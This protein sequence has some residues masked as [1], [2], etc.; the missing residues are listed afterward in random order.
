ML[1]AVLFGAVLPRLVDVREVGDLLATK[2]DAGEFGGLVALTLAS[3]AASAGILIAGLPGLR[4]R[5]AAAVN[6]VTTA[7]SY[8]LPAGGAAGAALN[9]TMLRKVGFGFQEIA[10]QALATGV[11]NLVARLVLPLAALGAAAFTSAVPDGVRG[12]G[13]LGLALAVGVLG[14][15][16][17]LFWGTFPAEKIARLLSRAGRLLPGKPRIGADKLELFRGEVRD[18]VH[19]RWA[20][21]SVTTLAYHLAT[22]GVLYVSLLAVGVTEAG[23]IETFA[24]YA[25]ARQVTA[26]PLTPGSAGVI[27]LALIGGLGLTGGDLPKVAAGV[28]L[29]RFFTFLLYLPAGGLAWLWWQWSVTRS[30]DE[31]PRTFHHPGDALRALAAA[32]LLG[33]TVLLLTPVPGGWETSV[34]RLV[35]GLPDLLYA[36]LWAVMQTGW[37]GAVAVTAALAL[38]AR[39]WT[40]AASL[41]AAGAAAWGLAK[42]VKAVAGRDRPGALLEEVHLRGDAVAGGVGFVAGHTAVAAALATVASAYLPRAYRR[43]LWGLV[44]AVA[45]ARVYLGAHLPLDV[46]GGTAL[47]WG[48]GAAVLFLLGTPPHLPSGARIRAVFP[49]LLPDSVPLQALRADIRR[50]VVYRAPD[51]SLFLKAIGRDQRDADFFDRLRSPG[52]FPGAPFATTRRQLEHEEFVL[53]LARHRGA[54]VPTVERFAAHPSGDC[55]LAM[56]LVDGT[57]LSA[58]PEVPDALLD[59]LW[60]QLAVLG[61]ARIAHRAIEPDA[62]VVDA[63]GQ[64]WLTSFGK[65]R[66]GAPVKA[67]RR[68]RD[69][70]EEITAKIV[71]AQ[72]AAAARARAGEPEFPALRAPRRWN[73][74]GP[75]TARHPGDVVRVAVGVF[76]VAFLTLYAADGFLLPVEADLFRLVNGMPDAAYRPLEV[77]MQAG[78]LGAVGAAAAVALAFGRVRLGAEL[79]AGGTLAWFLAKGLKEL[80]DRGRPGALLEEVVLR[81]A[82]DSGL[83][84]IS[85]HAAVAATLATIASAHVPRRLRRVFWAWAAVVAVSRVYV[86]AH[87]PFDVVA[88]LGLGLV[89][90]GTFHLLWG[91]PSILPTRDDIV[92]GLRLAVGDVSDVR[93]LDA[94][95]RGSVPFLARREDDGAGL[96]VKAVSRDH[97]DADLLFK[98]AR[99]A[100]LRGLEDESPFSTPRRQL[101]HEACLVM[102][103]EAAG[104]RVPPFAG[105]APCGGGTYLLAEEAVEDA[106]ELADLP[107]PS[108]DFLRALW[109]EVRALHRTRVAHRDLRAANVLVD[110]ED[111]PVLVDF[112][113]AEDGASDRRLAQDVAELLC[114]TTLRTG[115]ER[116]V[117]AAAAV[118]EPAELA[119]A[120]P[121]LQPL[122]FGSATRKALREKPGLLEEI[123]SAIGRATGLEAEEEARL[124]RLP[125]RSWMLLLALLGMAATTVALTGLPDVHDPAE[126]LAGA[127]LRWLAT[128]V[129]LICVSYAAGALALMGAYGRRLPFFLTARRQL[130]ASYSSRQ[131]LPGLG[132]AAVL[133]EY[134]H[135]SGASVREAEGAVGRTRLAGML[136]HVTGLVSAV[137]AAFA[138]RSGPLTLPRWPVLVAIAAVLAGVGLLVQLR[139]QRGLPRALRDAFAGL[140]LEGPAA[141]ATL[142][143]G[144][145]AVTGT[146]VLSFLATAQALGVEVGPGALAAAF[147]ATAPL[148]L[149]GPLPAGIGLVEPVLVLALTMLGGGV[150]ESVVA[151]LAHRA[152]SFW[153]PVLPGALAW[154]SPAPRS[155]PT[156]S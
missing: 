64:P 129:V 40:L 59:E 109:E 72:R 18:L 132:S 9:V 42:A 112:G 12:A 115:P 30:R 125:S 95:A 135:V 33:G 141:M 28:L 19:D 133:S 35:N 138:E 156:T 41:A 91:T 86:G 2:V 143:A 85:G 140:A 1:A 10:T 29:F 106:R 78:A 90:G 6:V 4:F 124:S 116:A 122:A 26:I 83:G 21:L 17:W 8:G 111:R 74:T 82:H 149:L 150:T 99:L 107:E 128:A 34:F 131:H 15:T 16:G 102:R 13:L 155:R 52:T 151:V 49:D 105:L 32:A 110:A 70:L 153:L 103:A 146:A 38:L 81:G 75:H 127:D 113:F 93:P 57:P 69:R 24:V 118:L 48:V 39:R 119:A 62:F 50:A 117:R 94:D 121:L 37:V 137:A 55:V 60:R 67:L 139:A 120:V 68:D 101:Q 80:A 65:A 58:L 7:V 104:V 3:V 27:E 76:L 154:R 20:P 51:R 148:R 79:A 100:T 25:I 114:S 134:L 23:V 88:G 71:G 123:K 126:V 87:F 53:Q 73:R 147:L 152:L 44:A 54:R 47:G 130:A 61:A 136:V 22:F 63:E 43:L 77:L 66:S 14:A 98:L 92:R 108:D 97:R 11:W 145:A 89:I 5:D 96:F 144:S 36:P 45:F 142:L 31:R 46:L 56:N 84:F